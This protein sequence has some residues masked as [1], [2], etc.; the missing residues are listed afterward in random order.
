VLAHVPE[1]DRPLV[2]RRLRS[3]WVLDDHDRA[4]DQLRFLAGE[5]ERSHPGA[6]ASL[7]E[8]LE[9]TLT[10][11][12]LGVRGTLKRT[13]AS[14]NPCESMIE[15][16]RHISRNVKRWQNGDMCLRWTA[17]GMLEAETQFRSITA[18]SPSSLSPSS[19]TSPP[20]AR[21]TPQPNPF[22]RP[23]RPRRPRSPRHP[24]EIA[25]HS[26]DRRREVPWRAGHPHLVE[27]AR[28]A[29]LPYGPQRL[30]A[31]PGV[32]LAA[33]Q[34]HLEALVVLAD[35]EEVDERGGRTN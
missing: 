33:H 7:R 8:G 34:E 9:E 5:L 4:L 16:V 1:R 22:R 25:I 29:R 11:T 13:L 27:A 2:R 35:A 24:L 6:A 30:V 18:T 10:V 23:S 26:Q 19:T 15:T 31:V 3:A 21:A 20:S 14:T 32:L 12:P 17:A 28:V